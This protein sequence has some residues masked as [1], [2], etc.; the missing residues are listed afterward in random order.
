MSLFV[1]D[2]S[3]WLIFICLPG[4]VP[5]AVRDAKHDEEEDEREED[6]SRDKVDHGG[7]DG[8]GDVAEAGHH[9]VLGHRPLLH[10]PPWCPPGLVTTQPSVHPQL[11]TV[12][13]KL[14]GPGPSQSG[15]VEGSLNLAN[16]AP[17]SGPH[18]LLASCW[19]QWPNAWPRSILRTET[20]PWIPRKPSQVRVRC[21][22]SLYPSAIWS[23]R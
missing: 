19:S 20:R 3:F 17:A 8:D 13:I 7:G 21:S 12:R 2:K 18:C 4:A 5:V 14:S 23:G 11:A 15:R 9:S 16:L 6:G 10:S 1:D 22:S